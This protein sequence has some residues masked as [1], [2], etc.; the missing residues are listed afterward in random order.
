[1]LRH[2]N[3][4]LTQWKPPS[5]AS[6]RSR[7][8]VAALPHRKMWTA[9]SVAGIFAPAR[10]DGEGPAETD[11]LGATAASG[12]GVAA[13]GAVEQATPI[14]NNRPTPRYLRSPILDG[15]AEVRR[16]DRHQCRARRTV[17]IVD[18]PPVL[19]A[20]RRPRR[21][22]QRPQRHHANPRRPVL[23]RILE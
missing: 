14:S 2:S 21:I 10:G 3:R 22:G 9:G 4:C 13:G 15:A 8:V 6:C 1:M 12:V 5:F 23:P 17:R 16:S 18:G 7:A 11:G 19:F 20:I